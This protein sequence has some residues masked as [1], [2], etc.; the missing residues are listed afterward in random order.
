MIYFSLSTTFLRL[1]QVTLGTSSVV[2]KYCVFVL[3]HFA[4]PLPRGRHPNE[5]LLYT[6]SKRAMMGI[7][8]HIPLSTTVCDYFVKE[9]TELQISC[10]CQALHTLF[11]M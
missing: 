6:I 3:P 2:C 8:T 4:Y 5:L 11:R 10:M 9:M 7:N 1:I